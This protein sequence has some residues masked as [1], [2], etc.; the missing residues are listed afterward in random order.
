VRVLAVEGG[1]GVELLPADDPL[2]DQVGLD[3]RQP[4]LVVARSEVPRRIHS[5]DP[6]TE[7]VDIVESMEAR[8]PVHRV[9]VP[10]PGR[11]EDRLVRLALDRPKAVHATHIVHA[12]HTFPPRAPASWGD[13]STRRRP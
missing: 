12:V 10:L 2:L 6:P 1:P 9:D 3:R 4:A 13:S 7:L 5:L 8:D 11:V